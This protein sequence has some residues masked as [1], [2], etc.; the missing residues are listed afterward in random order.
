MKLVAST[1]FRVFLGF[2]S[3][4]ALT[5]P[6]HL[7]IPVALHV[8]QEVCSGSRGESLPSPDLQN[9][10]NSLA[11]ISLVGNVKFFMHPNPQP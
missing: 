4:I 8:L 2:R 6:P 7:S 10:P 3:A 11:P 1:R 5:N 9:N